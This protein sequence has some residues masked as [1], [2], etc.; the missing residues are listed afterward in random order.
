MPIKPA[1]LRRVHVFE[2]ATDDDLK[3]L[4]QHGIERSV[5]EDEFFFFQ[6]DPATY[7]Y[8]LTSGR[9]KM[10]QVSTT[11]QQVNLRTINQ[12]QVFGAVGA[13]RERATYPASAQAFE[14]SSALAIE[15]GLMHEMMQTRPYLS[16][17][18]MQLMT[19]YIQ[20]M[21]ARYRELATEKV[22]QRI[23]R[24]MLRLVAAMGVRAEKGAVELTFTR[25]QLAEISGTTLF[26]VSRVFSE[27]ER[28]AIVEAGREKVRI[29]RPHDL[30]QIAE[31]LNK[32]DG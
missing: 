9:V 4:T 12:W 2:K 1:D 19:G 10:T 23:A 6:G 27:W 14:S 13:V 3:L 16:F 32:K 7:L 15:N 17:G 31:G 24:T 25:Q 29:L 28:Q 18:L 26:T 21:Q 20:E 22:E 5:E 30:V 11:G 8:V